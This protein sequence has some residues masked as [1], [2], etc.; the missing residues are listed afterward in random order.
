MQTSHAN[1]HKTLCIGRTTKLKEP[2]S[3]ND[4]VCRRVDLL[5]AIAL[6]GEQKVHFLK[7]LNLYQKDWIPFLE[8]YC[9]F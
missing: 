6:L 3:F 5:T 8:L 4:Y 7:F 1:E 9:K 2:G